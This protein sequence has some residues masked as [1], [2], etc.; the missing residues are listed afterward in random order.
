MRS[1]PTHTQKVPQVKLNKNNRKIHQK[2]RPLTLYTSTMDP[3]A[4]AILEEVKKLVLECW[5]IS[6]EKMK[7]YE[8]ISEILGEMKADSKAK[9]MTANSS[10]NII[11]P[12]P[13]TPST[14][15]PTIHQS[16]Y[17][18]ISTQTTLPVVH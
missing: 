17:T 7:S 15:T 18:S 5:A 16:S 11:P 14:P 13:H 1:N 12:V 4:H 9:G 2:R 6:R 8:K 10:S 3:A